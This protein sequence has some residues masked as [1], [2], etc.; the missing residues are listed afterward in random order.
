M[1]WIKF[2][3]LVINL[4]AQYL[5]NILNKMLLWCSIIISHIDKHSHYL[6]ISFWLVFHCFSLNMNQQ[7]P[8][9]CHILLLHATDTITSCHRHY[10]FLPSKKFCQTLLHPATDTIT[11]YQKNNILSKDTIISF[12]RQLCFLPQKLLFPAT[13][14]IASC[15]RHYS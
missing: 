3:V 5:L 11:S 13:D 1:S 12:Q 2:S 14:H 8:F 4:P 6:I 15:R 7:T 10:Y 9:L